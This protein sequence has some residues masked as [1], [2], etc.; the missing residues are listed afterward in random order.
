MA[1]DNTKSELYS[2][3]DPFNAEEDK[4][5]DYNPLKQKKSKIIRK[6]NEHKVKQVPARKKQQLKAKKIL[7]RSKELANASK[8]K[9]V[10]HVSHDLEFLRLMNTN[11]DAEYRHTTVN[12]TNNENIYN[13]CNNKNDQNAEILEH[14]GNEYDN[15]FFEIDSISSIETIPKEVNA[16]NENMQM[17]GIEQIIHF[18]RDTE[19][20]TDK[21]FQ[22]LNELF[23]K[24]NCTIVALQKQI[25]RLEVKLNY[26]KLPAT[27]V[28]CEA[29][30]IIENSYIKTLRSKGLPVKDVESLDSFEK[31]LATE[32][33]ANEI[34]SFDKNIF[35]IVFS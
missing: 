9:Q 1:L 7:R 33:Y 19:V 3:D 27:V 25:A 22:M 30:N 18:L 13:T 11:A 20:K 24:Q 6:K 8:K 4:D 14:H 31:D 29:N 15:M 16:Q 23:Y 2:D 35:I 17:N 34:V 28:E 21:Q 32:N 10:N 12:H 26:T 5:E